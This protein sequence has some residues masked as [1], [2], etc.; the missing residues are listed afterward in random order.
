MQISRRWAFY[1][2]IQYGTGFGVF[3]MLVLTLVYMTNFYQEPT[4]FDSRQNGAE[5]GIDCGG[6]C[7]RVCAFEVKKP[8]VQWARSF[9]VTQGQYNAVAYIENTNALVAAPEVPYTVSLYDTQGLIV[10]RTGITILPADSVYPVF[11]ARIDT[12]GRTPT[13]TIIELG[14]IPLW[15]SAVSGRDQF[16][17]QSRTLT[18]ADV[19]PRLE[20]QVFN[21]AFIPVT[22]LEV[23]A[24][25][26]DAQGNALTSSRTFIDTLGPKSAE[27]A[28]F[29]WPEP[30][31]K[32]L[33]SCDVPTDVALA[34][35]VSGSMNNDSDTPP[36]PIT[37]VLAAAQS[38]TARLQERDQASLVTFASDA[39]VAHTLT[40][41]IA[42][43]A[44]DI[45]AL[46]IDPKEEQG[47]TNTGEALYKA[48]GELTSTRHNTEA[49]K[50][51]VL[52]TDGL[53]T[54]PDEEPEQYARDAATLIKRQGIN[55][56]TIGLGE[57]VN[58]D[59]VS[60]LASSPKQAYR[61]VSVSEVDKIYKNITAEICEDGAAII[62]I[63][64]KTSAGFSTLN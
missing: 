34:I 46:V 35:D 53:A 60:E 20:A 42:Q 11:E 29:T 57:N 50:V 32:T 37:S 8:V 36:E 30:I 47:S 3:S 1:R 18:G 51:L 2:R 26:F 23:V 19:K 21:N 55:L 58:M 31:A 63:I 45:A 41:D 40:G 33:R 39:I 59:F 27:T 52:L 17:V 16:T 54:A 22:N 9:K 5:L 24:T 4:C 28:V 25:I 43:V 12:Q 15:V 62:E 7:T 44:Q 49:R 48:G 38:F 56:F 6:A 64:P 14:D 61:A 10:Q 13:Q